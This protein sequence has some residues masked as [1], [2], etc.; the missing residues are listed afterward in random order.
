MEGNIVTNGPGDGCS[1]YTLGMGN[2]NLGFTVGFK[3]GNEP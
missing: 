2:L 3:G 1:V